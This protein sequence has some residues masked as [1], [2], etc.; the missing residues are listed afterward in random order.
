MKTGSGMKSL[1]AR[2]VAI[3]LQLL[4]TS[5][6]YDEKYYNLAAALRSDSRITD[7]ESFRREYFQIDFN[8]SWLLASS[9]M[10]NVIEI[11]TMTWGHPSQS[12]IF[13]TF[14]LIMHIIG[15]TATSY[16]LMQPWPIF[17]YTFVFMFCNAIPLIISA[18]FMIDRIV[19]RSSLL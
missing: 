3:F 11:G 10:C 13:N 17:A 7:D 2:F 15:L 12:S 18:L 9:I 4:V 19:L 1:Q 8:F 6:L 14:S 16:M 5:V